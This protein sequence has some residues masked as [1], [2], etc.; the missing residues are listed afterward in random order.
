MLYV[1][2]STFRINYFDAFYNPNTK[3]LVSK[4]ADYKYHCFRNTNDDTLLFLWKQIAEPLSKLNSNLN[5]EKLISDS[6][7]KSL[8][9]KSDELEILKSNHKTAECQNICSQQF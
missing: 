4:D 3:M 1:R 2:E 9:D 7:E 6:L 5:S 8:N